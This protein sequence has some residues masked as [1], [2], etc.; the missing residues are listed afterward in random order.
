MRGTI[1][2]LDLVIKIQMGLVECFAPV[3]LVYDLLFPW[4]ATL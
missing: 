3:R 1:D 2:E 4:R